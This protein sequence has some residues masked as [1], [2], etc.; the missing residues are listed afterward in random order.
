MTPLDVLTKAKALIEQGWTQ[1][2][3]ARNVHAFIVPSTD[4]S[5][6][7]FCMVG[8]LRKAADYAGNQPHAPEAYVSAH[9][10]LSQVVE[11]RS[12]CYSIPQ[13]ND[14]FTTTKDAVL[15]MFDAAIERTRPV[16]T[17]TAADAVAR[18]R[19]NIDRLTNATK[20]IKNPLGRR[21]AERVVQTVL[22]ALCVLALVTEPGELVVLFEALAHLVKDS[23]D[24]GANVE[25]VEALRAAIKAVV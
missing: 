7:C 17:V 5:A 20:A 6:T 8:A 10:A 23:E 4:P 19:A 16:T 18:T 2:S 1:R 21:L 13:F 11:A 24:I 12:G 9:D 25:D 22:Q 14:D 3:Y 15:D